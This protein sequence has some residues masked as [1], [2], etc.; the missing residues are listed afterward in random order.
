[1]VVD[2]DAYLEGGRVEGK[3]EK[4]VLG[5]LGAVR[6][7]GGQEESFVVRVT[8][9]GDSEEEVE[10]GLVTRTFQLVRIGKGRRE[11]DGGISDSLESAVDGH[12]QGCG[13]AD[14][15]ER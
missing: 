4:E 10:R 7:R 15:A 6:V 12:L 3:I 14:A 5:A 2:L 1:M 9:E 8:W 11:V 13:H